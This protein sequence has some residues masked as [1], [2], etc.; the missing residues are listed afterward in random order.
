MNLVLVID[1]WKEHVP[2]ITVLT[3]GFEIVRTV[4]LPTS[5][6]VLL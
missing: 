6:D 2:N 4:L 3:V 1:F 5:P